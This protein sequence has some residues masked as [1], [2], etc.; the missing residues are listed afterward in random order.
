MKLRSLL[1]LCL[2]A[3]LPALAGCHGKVG[4]PQQK[5]GRV[6][7]ACDATFENILDQEIDVFEYTYT[8]ANRQ[9]LVVPYYVSQQAAFDSLVTP[10][11]D[12]TT[13][14]AARK[15]TDSERTRLKNRKLPVRE[16]QIAVDAVAIIVN[17]ENDVP[18]LSIDELRS[19]L[20]GEVMQWDDV[21]PS[22]LDSIT[23]IFDENGSSLIK[24][25]EDKV[26]NGKPFG[27]NIHAQG[28][29]SK[30]FEAV[31]RM[32]GAIGIIGVSWISRDLEGVALSKEEVRAR[33]T[34]SEATSF[35]FDR[36]VR[37]LPI[38]VS[39]DDLAYKPYQPYIHDGR[40]PLHRPIYMITT[41]PGG[42][43]GAFYSFVTSLQGQKV[44]QLTGV[45]P[46]TYTPRVVQIGD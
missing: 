12:I 21:W 11:N 32:K 20:T 10:D 5:I 41:V 14:V 15:L 16:Q 19:I 23:V 44:I 3:L 27:S 34:G 29:S 1:P 24:Y 18:S 28:S 26:M 31:N 39:R 43:S 9:V 40:Y 7:V 36:N 42:A 38:S 45:L 4:T 37:V 2:L 33:S 22:A 6:E 25:M 35:D 8:T 13:V 17:N 46:A 30:V